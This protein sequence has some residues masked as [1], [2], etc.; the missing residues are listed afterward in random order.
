MFSLI[1][2]LCIFCAENAGCVSI[3]FPGKLIKFLVSEIYNMTM[4]LLEVWWEFSF[5][6]GRHFMGTIFMLKI[7]E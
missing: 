3:I 5:I 1:L 6:F 2:V 4:F 7:S